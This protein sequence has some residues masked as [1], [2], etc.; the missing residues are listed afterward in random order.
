MYRKIQFMMLLSLYYARSHFPSI[1]AT[2]SLTSP[3]QHPVPRNIRRGLWR[4]GRG[5]AHVYKTP[6]EIAL[7][8]QYLGI[9]HLAMTSSVI[10]VLAV[11]VAVAAS[12][13]S[14]SPAPVRWSRCWDPEEGRYYICGGDIVD[15]GV[16]L[17]AHSGGSGVAGTQG[18]ASWLNNVLYSARPRIQTRSS[19]QQRRGENN[20][21]P[22]QLVTYITQRK[23][24]RFACLNS[25]SCQFLLHLNLKP[26]RN[27]RTV[28]DKK[29][30]E[31][32]EDPD[33]QQVSSHYLFR[34][35]K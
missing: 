27:G 6:H 2:L 15:D 23:L 17:S 11:L 32:E 25:L 1:A 24:K 8:L 28:V 12:T 30:D 18:T 16:D 3:L 26:F 34:L 21:R 4:A 22:T 10:T 13:A 31:E 5:C 9:P 29:Q 14:A 7:P 20:S 19:S 35:D 33:K